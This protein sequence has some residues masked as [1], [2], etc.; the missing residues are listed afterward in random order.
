MLKRALSKAQKVIDETFD[1]AIDAEYA[2]VCALIDRDA[3]RVASE[4]YPSMVVWNRS[5]AG[6]DTDPEFVTATV[7]ITRLNEA[8]FFATY[9]YGVNRKTVGVKILWQ[10]P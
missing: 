4:G 5:W 1:Y 7:L 9:H 8:G 2:K 3:K 10:K 6:N